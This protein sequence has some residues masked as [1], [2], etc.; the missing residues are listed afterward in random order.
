KTRYQGREAVLLGTTMAPG[1]NVTEVGAEVARTLNRIERDLPL[2]IELGRISDQ[3]QGVT[4]SMHECL[5]AFG[6]AAGVVLV[7]SLMALGWRAGIVV[8]LTIPLVLVAT[9]F[10]L[11]LMGIDLHRISLGALVIALGLLV[12]DAMIAVEMMD[13]KLKEGHDRLAAATFAYT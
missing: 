11:S 9:I 5:E 10:I 7:V 1:V 8:A 3:A 4:R 12:D 2:G 6:E 13:R